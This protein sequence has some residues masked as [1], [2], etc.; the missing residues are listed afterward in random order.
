MGTSTRGSPSSGRHVALPERPTNR[1]RRYL[2]A[3]DTI[4]CCRMQVDLGGESQH[5]VN[6]MGGCRNGGGDVDP[7]RKVGHRCEA[8][9]FTALFPRAQSAAVKLLSAQ[10][11]R[12]GSLARGGSKDGRAVPCAIRSCPSR[13]RGC[14]C[15]RERQLQR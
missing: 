1:K 15:C 3:S 7:Q 6:Q 9:A 8:V 4:V 14:C 13:S 10:T 2:R 12:C 11:W 5:V